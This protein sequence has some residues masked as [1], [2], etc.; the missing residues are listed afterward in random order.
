MDTRDKTV[1][2]LAGWA[3]ILGF[4]FVALGFVVALISAYIAYLQ[5]P[6]KAPPQNQP[7]PEIKSVQTKSEPD[8][9]KPT[10]PP[11]PI[12]IAVKGPP[13]KK[14]DDVNK[15]TKTAP[16]ISPPSDQTEFVQLFNKKDLDG[17]RNHPTIERK[18]R[19]EGVLLSSPPLSVLYSTRSD[20]KDFH[21]KAEARMPDPTTEGG[22]VFRAPSPFGAGEKH[23]RGYQAVLN[24]HGNPPTGSLYV[25]AAPPQ[26]KAVPGN[27]SEF[28]PSDWLI[29]EV[30]AIGNRFTVKI[31][32]TTTLEYEDK[33]RQFVTGCIALRNRSGLLEIRGVEIKEL[34]RAP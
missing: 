17:W 21:L 4:P 15:P 34:S 19:V 31:N 30:I 12:P 5:V 26:G 9:I 29:L 11:E 7:A 28:N 3:N 2:R 16:K 23:V 24:R 32:G 14:A 8:S 20:Y 6:T 27:S 1:Q 25:F 18:W 33:Q 22:I 13:S 10:K